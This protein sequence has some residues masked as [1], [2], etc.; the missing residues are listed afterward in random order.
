MKL[1]VG[2]GNPGPRYAETIHNVGFA[3]VDE[4]ARRHAATFSSSPAE[5]LM[6][7]LSGLGDGV[8]LV[9]PS[10][11]MNLSGRA[12]GGLQR[13]Y[14]IDPADVLVVLDEVSLPAG[15]LRARRGGTAGGHRGLESV[16]DA[17]GT[18]AV[19]RLRLGVGRGDPRRDLSDHVLAPPRPEEAGIIREAVIRAADAVERFAT[20]G[21]D[22]VM[23]EFNPDPA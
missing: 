19:A 5:A 13:Y 21:I 8:I 2:L 15:K 18:T 1:V 11:F 12:V 20:D 7:K 17:L 23:Q 9:K 22:R 6:T 16:L 4:I 3:V 10:T 14:R